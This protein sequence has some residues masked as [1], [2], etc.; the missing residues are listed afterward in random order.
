L[1]NWGLKSPT[2]LL[3]SSVRNHAEMANLEKKHYR[4]YLATEVKHQ[5]TGPNVAPRAAQEAEGWNL[6]AGGE[7]LPAF[8]FSGPVRVRCNLCLINGRIKGIM[9]ISQLPGIGRR[10][11]SRGSPSPVFLE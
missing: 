1:R 10:A 5:A 9:G 2:A 6:E 8:S 3:K 11:E 7:H 4:K